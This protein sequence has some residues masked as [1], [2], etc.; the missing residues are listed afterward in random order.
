MFYVPAPIVA[1]NV[2]MNSVD[3]L[4][5]RRSTNAAQRNEKRLNMSLFTMVLDLAIHNAYALLC[6]LH[7][8]V[9]EEELQVSLMP[10]KEFKRCIAIQ[11]VRAAHHTGIIM[12]NASE[13]S[14]SLVDNAIPGGEIAGVSASDHHC[15]CTPG[16]IS[17]TTEAC[18]GASQSSVDSAANTAFNSNDGATNNNDLYKMLSHN[19]E[20]HILL[21]TKKK[22]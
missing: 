15:V 8:E 5:Q 14:I 17:G 10:Y 18:M 16:E 19:N 21:H 20:P 13:D 7:D 1:Y 3:I 6:W 2:Y 12:E 22:Y 9:S 11:L 4:D